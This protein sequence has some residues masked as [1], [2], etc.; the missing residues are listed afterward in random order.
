[1][2]ISYS[3][4][5]PFIYK[6]NYGGYPHQRLGQAFY[7]YFDLHKIT[8]EKEQLDKLYNMGNDEAFAYIMENI[9]DWE[10]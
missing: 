9:I 5:K 1:M 7:N 6:Y 10:N 8:S 2:K 3:L 4:F